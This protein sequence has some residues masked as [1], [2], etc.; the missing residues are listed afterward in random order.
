MNIFIN[1]N[2]LKRRDRL[3][4]SDTVISCGG[5]NKSEIISLKIAQAKKGFQRMKSNLTNKRISIQTKRRARGC[6]IE[7][8]LVY[9][10]EAWTI[11]KQFKK[12]LDGSEIWFLRRTLRISRTARNQTK[13]S[14]EKPTQQVH[15]Q[16]EHVKV[17]QPL[18]GHVVRREKLE[19]LVTTG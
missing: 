4:F 6:Y 13:Q 1:G 3:N 5:H 7:P 12:K 14:Y 2:K 10:C 18:F 15:S 8:I 17:R 16:T 19:H 11:A 9:V